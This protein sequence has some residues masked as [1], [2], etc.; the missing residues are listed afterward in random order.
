MK[1]EQID[2][3]F[4]LHVFQGCQATRSDEAAHL[5]WVGKYPLFDMGRA[6]TSHGPS[7]S[8]KT[9][10]GRQSN[11][12]LYFSLQVHINKK[13]HNDVRRNIDFQ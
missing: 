9:V 1:N 13:E 7:L 8:G 11:L 2:A 10:V 12:G 5:F 3:Q 6:L 4:I